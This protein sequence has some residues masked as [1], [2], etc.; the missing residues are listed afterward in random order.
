[1]EWRLRR[2]S[3]PGRGQR[4]FRFVSKFKPHGQ[5]PS[6]ALLLLLLPRPPVPSCSFPCPS[7]RVL[8][9][10]GQSPEQE[11][12]A[13]SPL[14]PAAAAGGTRGAGAERGGS[15][16]RGRAGAAEDM[17]VKPPSRAVPGLLPA[18]G[19]GR[20]A[21]RCGDEGDARRPPALGRARAPP[22][23]PRGAGGAFPGSRHFGGGPRRSGPNSPGQPSL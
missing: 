5:P 6:P 14:L 7:L 15:A 20:G 13:H 1:M 22:G 8:G 10:A 3:R 21:R 16:R 9:P 17:E 18:R 12:V 2:R 23:G 19:A 11:P 4:L